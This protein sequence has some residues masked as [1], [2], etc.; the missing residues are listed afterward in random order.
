MLEAASIGSNIESTTIQDHER[1][2]MHWDPQLSSKPH[3]T[4]VAVFKAGGRPDT[5]N[6][7]V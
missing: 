3:R 4:G 6:R 7:Y 1:G 5:M 2:N